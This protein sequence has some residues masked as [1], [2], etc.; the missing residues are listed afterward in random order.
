MC[1]WSC[2]M[3]FS[4][5]LAFGPSL[6][7]ETRARLDEDLDQASRDKLALQMYHKKSVNDK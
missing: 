5:L 1:S 7:E 6:M 2:K 4:S 3:T